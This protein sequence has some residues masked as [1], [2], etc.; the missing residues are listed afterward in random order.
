M[1]YPTHPHHPH[2]SMCCS[3]HGRDQPQVGVHCDQPIGLSAGGSANWKHQGRTTV[4]GTDG[5]AF[6]NDDDDDDDD[7]DDNH[8]ILD[9]I[10][11]FRTT[12]IE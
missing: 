7:D 12:P 6:E 3:S 8:S 4:V 1:I 9:Y 11:S 5:A 10:S 2:L